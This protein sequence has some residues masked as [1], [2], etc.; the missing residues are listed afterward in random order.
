M[1]ILLEEGRKKRK[2]FPSGAAN[3]EVWQCGLLER[4]WRNGLPALFWGM[5]MRQP[6]FHLHNPMPVISP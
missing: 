4:L 6:T 2:Q 5:P 1:K 3:P